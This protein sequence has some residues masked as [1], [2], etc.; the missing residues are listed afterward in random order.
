M[1]YAAVQSRGRLA[2]DWLEWNEEGTG[3]ES[4]KHSYRRESDWDD[5]HMKHEK[6][7][8][9][10]E[11]RRTHKNE[12]MVVYYVLQWANIFVENV[13]FCVTI[14]TLGVIDFQ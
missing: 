5:K 1:Y 11:K 6:P 14:R 3:K 10:H 7:K 9:K 4:Q 8:K 13:H 2:P 12:R